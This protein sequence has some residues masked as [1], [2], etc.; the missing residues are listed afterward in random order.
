MNTL[1]CNFKNNNFNLSCC[2]LVIRTGKCATHPSNACIKIHQRFSNI[3]RRDPSC[4]VV[5]LRTFIGNHPRIFNYSVHIIVRRLKPNSRRRTCFVSAGICLL[6]PFIV[7]LLSL[8]LFRVFTCN[9]N[10]SKGKKRLLILWPNVDSGSVKGCLDL[11][12]GFGLVTARSF[13]LFL[14]AADL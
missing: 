14:C 4:N 6:F 11:T 8:S 5:V 3:K 7:C 1:F 2:K 9:Y 12:L 10:K 13:G